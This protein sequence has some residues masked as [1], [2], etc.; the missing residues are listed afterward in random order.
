MPLCR[1]SFGPYGR[2]MIRICKEES[3]HQRQ[4]FELLMTMMRGTDEQRAMVQESV[5]RFWWPALMMFGPP[6][7]D[8]P[9]TEQS[10]AWGI[11]SHTNDELRQRFVDMSVPQAKALGVTFPDPELGWNEERGAHDFGQPDWDEFWD[12]VKG[13]GPCNAQRIAHRK[14]AWDD[15]AWVREAAMAFANGLGFEARSARTSTSGDRR[16]RDMPE[17]IRGEWPLY[18]VFVRG[19]RGLNHVHVGSLHAADDEMALRHARDV[20]TR[21]NEGVSIWV[22]RVRRDHG[23]E[24]GR[25]GSAVRAERRQ[26]LPAPDVL[27]DPRQ[28]PHM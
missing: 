4:G 3:F 17:Q 13:N 20:Y 1:T 10:M 16:R 7:D 21:R 15:G 5:N 22:V 25:E 19:K 27:R 23:V 9:N 2:A 24:P 26:G 18:E 6:D 14:A 12:V 28:R 8:S 11:K